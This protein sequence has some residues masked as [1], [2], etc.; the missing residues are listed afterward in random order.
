MELIRKLGTRLNKLGRMESWGVFWCSFDNCNKEVERRLSDGKKAKSCGC[1]KNK[2]IYNFQYGK[3]GKLSPNFGKKRTEEQRKRYSEAQKGKHPTEETRQKMKESAIERNK[4]PEN[5]GMFGKQR[6][7]ESKQKQAKARTGKYTGENSPHWQNGKSFEEYGIEFNKP[8]K[9][10]ILKRANY[11]CQDPNCKG[12]H[13][14]LH[15]HH[16]DY[17][18]KNNNPKN[19]IALC[20]SCHAKTNGKNNRTYWTDY[21]QNIIIN[22]L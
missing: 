17:N 4:N 10:S 3:K 18:K 6:T 9:H 8:L 21:Y 22:I 2:G 11:T 12:E 1:I 14:K 13:K 15:V 7:E 16:I 5:N 19:L 20:S